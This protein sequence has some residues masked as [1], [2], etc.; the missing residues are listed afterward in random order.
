MKEL[1]NVH[2]GHRERVKQS[3]FENGLELMQPHQVLEYLLFFAIPYKDTNVL[4]HQLI[5]RF[6]SLDGVFDA[7]VNDL[8]KIKGITKNAALL[9]HTLPEVFSLYQRNKNSPKKVLN[10]NNI[11]PYLRSLVSL[12]NNEYL[13]IICL[14][15]KNGIIYTEQLASGNSSVSLSSKEIVKIAMLHQ[16][17]SV[18]LCHNHPSDIVLPSDADINST[19]SI[20]QTL[21]TL[22]IKLLDHIIIGK[23][24]A[25]SFFLKSV[26]SEK[27]L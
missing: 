12:K 15:A 19:A 14:D 7:N 22:D 24:T 8:V 18:I 1:K 13:Y 2:Q 10:V 17:K 9:L 5:A 25:Y 16:A 27:T 6:G 4:A 11:I 26:L 20:R 21:A 23:D 3:V